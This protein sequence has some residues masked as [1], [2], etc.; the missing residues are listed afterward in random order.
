MPLWRFAKVVKLAAANKADKAVRH[1]D[2][3][4]IDHLCEIDYLCDIAV[5][6]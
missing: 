1:A 5:A 6:A 4:H 3:H 2:Y